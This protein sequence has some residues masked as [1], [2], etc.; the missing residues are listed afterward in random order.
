[1]RCGAFRSSP[2][3]ALQVEMSEM[4]ID[5]RE[6]QLKMVYWSGIKGHFTNHPVKKKYWRVA[7]GNMSRR[8]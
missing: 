6:V 8:V 4:P 2:V 3:T 1:M 7:A 5:I